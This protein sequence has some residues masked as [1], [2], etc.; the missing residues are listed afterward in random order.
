MQIK[1]IGHARKRMI[2][3]GILDFQIE[4]ILKNPSMVLRAVK[5]RYLAIGRSGN[6]RITIIFEETKNYKRVITVI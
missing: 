6:M 5:G 2:R 1:Y 3:R 4:D